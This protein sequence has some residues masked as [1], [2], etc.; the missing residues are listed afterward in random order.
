VLFGTFVLIPQIAE[1]PAGGDVGLGLDATQA[2][3]L[4]AP[5]G[6]MMLIAA[7][8]VGRVSERVGSR[9]PL[10]VGAVIA[11]GGLVGM[12]L[13]HDSA[14]LIVLWG[15]IMNTGVG[16]AFAALPNLVIDAVAAHETGEATGVNTIARNIGASLGGQV[17]ASIVA[18]HVLAGGLPAN[19]G[20]EIAFLMSAG[21][22]LLA[23]V[24]GLLI[25]AGRAGRVRGLV[26]A[27][28]EA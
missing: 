17:A 18:T 2:G 20:F 9:L 12:A 8:I 10:A 7:P 16:C 19:R 5:G 6:L 21:V 28:A 15:A 27:P 23:G 26:P 24:C 25:P 13:A 11:A 22:A 1:L 3:L 4:M 14:G